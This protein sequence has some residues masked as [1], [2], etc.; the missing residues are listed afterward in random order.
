MN[1][2]KVRAFLGA[3]A[4]LGMQ[5]MMVEEAFKALSAPQQ[6]PILAWCFMLGPVAAFVVFQLELC[7]ICCSSPSSLHE[8]EEVFKEYERWSRAQQR[9]TPERKE[10][11]EQLKAAISN[12][13]K[14]SDW[15]GRK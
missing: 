11:D 14:L 2:S 5:V 9:S 7:R 6:Y 4:L 15:R 13:T 8:F 1:G 10:A 3:L 12:V